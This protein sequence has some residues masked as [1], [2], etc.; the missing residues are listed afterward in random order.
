MSDA[1]ETQKR[2]NEIQ[3]SDDFVNIFSKV[4]SGTPG[5]K[6]VIEKRKEEIKCPK[7][8]NILAGNEK[9]CPQC[10]SKVK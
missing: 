7:C 1:R 8:Q 4:V 2:M 9:F 6:T 5:Y 10:G 3:N